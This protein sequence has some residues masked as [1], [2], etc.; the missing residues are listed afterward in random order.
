V[1]A[2]TEHVRALH[3]AKRKALGRES[4]E[5]AKWSSAAEAAPT[6]AAEALGGKSSDSGRADAVRSPTV[7]VQEEG[8]SSWHLQARVI[9]SR[10][11]T[12]SQQQHTGG[13]GG[14]GG[15][16]DDIEEMEDMQVVG[17]SNYTDGGVISLIDASALD[18]MHI[19]PSSSHSLGQQ[20]PNSH[21]QG[22]APASSPD[23][24]LPSAHTA[25]RDIWSVEVDF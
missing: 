6:A 5:A 21:A 18:G 19:R 9:S 3:E 25:P 1:Q 11:G 16:D 14:G 22:V 12:R 13:G 7:T 24:P 17:G 20:H 4:E 15:E 8:G 10:G 23:S 2:F